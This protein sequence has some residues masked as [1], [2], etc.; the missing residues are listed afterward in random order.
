MTDTERKNTLYENNI[1]AMNQTKI[2][3]L[4]QKS[5]GSSREEVRV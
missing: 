4:Q 2:S 1:T 3:A 5:K